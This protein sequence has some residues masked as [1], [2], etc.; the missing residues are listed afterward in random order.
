M[1]VADFMTFPKMC[2]VC[3][4]IQNCDPDLVCGYSFILRV[5]Q[6]SRYGSIGNFGGTFSLRVL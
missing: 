1:A 2:Y 3:D 4:Y 5:V 6:N